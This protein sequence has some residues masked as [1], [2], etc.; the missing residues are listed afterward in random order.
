[1]KSQLPEKFI[2]FT[3]GGS[4]GNPGPAAY[5]FVAFNE[6]KKIFSGSQYLGIATNNQA[7]YKGVVGALQYV[8]SIVLKNKNETYPEI[9]FFLD[10][11]LIV[12]QMNGNYKIK[13]EDL[14]P[15]YWQIREMILKL[16]GKITFDYIP[17]EK[18]KEADKLVNQELDRN[19]SF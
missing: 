4:R 7:E 5:G 1:M 10:S 15:L 11:K 16:G 13:N 9:N 6:K 8:L 2:I 17:R 18:N 19:L 12:E 3:D 14:K